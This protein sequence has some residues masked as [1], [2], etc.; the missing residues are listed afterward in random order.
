VKRSSDLMRTVTQ[1]LRDLAEGA[2]ASEAQYAFDEV[3][4]SQVSEALK[5][6]G[7]VRVPNK[8][9]DSSLNSFWRLA[10]MEC[11]MGP[12]CQGWTI[13]D[14]GFIEACRVCD[15]I[16]SHE[17]A[18]ET[19]EAF[20]AAMPR[21]KIPGHPPESRCHPSCRGW[22]TCLRDA[23]PEGTEITCCDDCGIWTGDGALEEALKQIRAALDAAKG[24]VS[25]PWPCRCP[26]CGNDGTRGQIRH[27]EKVF[28]WR[29][30]I[31]LDAEGKVVVDCDEAYGK[32]GEGYDDE[33]D[34]HWECHACDPPYR[35]KIKAE[36]GGTIHFG[37][38]D[39]VVKPVK[40]PGA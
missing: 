37:Y 36:D 30:M 20:I 13:T 10:A 28:L 40:L 2:H 6:F 15:K 33:G 16:H 32:T 31:G 19:A 35:W 12:F 29:P 14:I 25:K 11:P 4:V 8:E 18:I 9:E 38:K 1:I 27:L 17:K 23:E 34:A 22:I 7:V 26:E 39:D 3:F 21:L 24:L 5:P